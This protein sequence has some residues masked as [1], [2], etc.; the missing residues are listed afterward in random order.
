MPAESPA[1]ERAL[2]DLQGRLG[3]RF[4]EPALLTRA[5]THP[6]FLPEHPE[7]GEN[8]QRLEFLGDAVV[9][10]FL[11]ER[12]YGLYANEREGVLTKRRAALGKGTF[13]AQLAR[14]LGLAPCLRLSA[15]EEAAG[16]RDR[17]AALEDAF[18]ALV[19][20]VY[21]D[22]GLDTARRILEG[23][24]GDLNQRLAGREDLE[25]PKGRLQELV[26]PRH[27]NDALR[28]AVVSTD[29]A[30]HARAYEV[31]VYLRDQPLGSGRGTSK[32]LAEEEA[33]RAALAGW[34]RDPAA[35]LA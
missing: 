7:A 29:G 35:L 27:G 18:E 28:Y 31:T 16:G 15:G 6:S 24:Y 1:P 26:Q 17:D 12:L 23:I 14:E 11:T 19:G 22:A 13:L 8:N 20:A 32:K 5:L 2:A 25:N 3:H 4:R 34:A 10:L 33:A 9:Q 30:D 21:L